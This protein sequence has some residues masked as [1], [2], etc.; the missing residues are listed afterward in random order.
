[1]QVLGS[2]GD[3]LSHLPDCYS[4][5]ALVPDAEGSYL[6]CFSQRKSLPDPD[7]SPS[8]VRHLATCDPEQEKVVVVVFIGTQ[9]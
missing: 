3:T 8:Q 7:T 9:I 4:L 6:N 1:M 2:F 5:Y